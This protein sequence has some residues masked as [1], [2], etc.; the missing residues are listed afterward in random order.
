MKFIRKLRDDA[1]SH[2]PTPM[3]R[4]E[5]HREL[6]PAPPQVR[7][8]VRTNLSL[9]RAVL[10]ESPPAAAADAPQRLPLVLAEATSASQP[11]AQQSTGASQ[12]AQLVLNEVLNPGQ[13]EWLD[14]HALRKVSALTG[15]IIR[16]GR[17]HTQAREVLFAH[18]T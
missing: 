17:V 1:L 14:T 6:L 13:G 3:S 2:L 18:R 4:Q 16:A 11:P 8:A 9:P 15:K 12:V 7:A 10:I 5:S